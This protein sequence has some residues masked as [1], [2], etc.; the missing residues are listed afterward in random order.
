MTMPKFDYKN[1][2]K[3]GF[4]T[5]NLKTMFQLVE[6]EYPILKKV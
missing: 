2:I 5:E 6:M 4:T 1:N 3:N